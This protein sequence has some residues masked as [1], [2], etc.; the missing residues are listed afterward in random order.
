[1][2]KIIDRVPGPMFDL[3]MIRNDKA[4]AVVDARGILSPSIR[5]DGQGNGGRHRGHD[6]LRLEFRHWKSSAG[7]SLSGGRVSNSPRDAERLSGERSPV[8]DD[9]RKSDQWQ[10]DLHP[11]LQHGRLE[12]PG[13]MFL[14]LRGQIHA[15]FGFERMKPFEQKAAS[16]EG[17]ALALRREQQEELQTQEGRSQ[18][19]YRPEEHV[20]EVLLTPRT[21]DIFPKE[22]DRLYREHDEQRPEHEKITGI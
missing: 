13:H 19:R 5:L 21:R 12:E 15:I 8:L 22:M 6:F 9:D 1:M 10:D 14:R 4:I 3:P 7:F 20:L 17:I 16:L 11:S 2:D 18:G